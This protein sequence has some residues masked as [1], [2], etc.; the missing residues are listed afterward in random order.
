MGSLCERQRHD[1]SH[2]SAFLIERFFLRERE[3]ERVIKKGRREGGREREMS[4]CG[5]VGYVR[6]CPL[7]VDRALK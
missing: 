3:R 2:S 6:E 7:F 5:T 4:L 1:Q